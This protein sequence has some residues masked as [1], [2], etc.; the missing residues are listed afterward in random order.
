MRSPFRLRDLLGIVLCTGVL[1]A[2]EPE[3]VIP[4]ADAAPAIDG[5][6]DDACWAEAAVL[7]DFSVAGAADPAKKAKEARL[8]C[9]DQ[10][11]YISVTTAEPAST[12]LR[13]EAKGRASAVWQDDC[14][15]LFIRAGQNQLDYD[16]FITN[17]NG[18]Q[19]DVRRRN[20]KPTGGAHAGWRVASAR[21][22]T[23]WTVEFMIPASDLEIDSFRRADLIGLK[24]GS[25]DRTAR[26]EDPDLSVWPPKASYNPIESVG[27]A[28]IESANLLV[29]PDGADQARWGGDGASSGP[30][31]DGEA[32]VWRFTAPTHVQQDVRMRP[33]QSYKMSF[34]ARAGGDALVRMRAP[35]ADPKADQRMDLPVV[36][37]DGYVAYVKRFAAGPEGKGLMVIGVDDVGAG[38]TW[39]RDLRVSADIAPATSGSAI[40]VI[41]GD[42]PLVVTK[43]RVIDARIERAFCGSA[44]DG[45]VKSGQ[46]DGNYWEYNQPYGGAGVD[47]A[48][49]ANNGYHIAF[50][51]ALGFQAVVVRG[52]VQAKL[53]RDVAAF[54]DP[55]SGSLVY[56]FPGQSQDSRAFLKETAAT[57]RV[58]FFD[59][60]DGR[61]AD[62]SF[63]R[64]HHGLGALEASASDAV[65]SAEGAPSDLVRKHLKE[66]FGDAD[67]ASFAVGGGAAKLDVPGQRWVH[68]LSQ[69]LAEETALAAI[70][71]DLA[72]AAPAPGLQLTVRVQDPLNPRLEL[73]GADYEIAGNGRARIVCDFPD[74]IVPKG[75]QLWVSLRS[76]RPVTLAS[77]RVERY[78]VARAQ[79]QAEALAYRTFLL[80]SFYS[81][82]SEARP[83]NQWWKPEDEA[84]FVSSEKGYSR[85]VKEIVETVEQCKAIDPSDDLT[86]QYDQWIHQNILRRAKQM[87]PYPT[88]FD[89]IPG[90]PEWASLAHQAWMQAREVP[91]WWLD[92]RM[93][94]TG[95]IGGVVGD[96]TD[97]FGNYAPFPFFERDGVGG[98]VLRAGALLAETAEKNNLE[99]GWN[100]HSTD[101]L[102]AY[103]EGM[104]HE[105]IMLYWNYGDPVYVERCMIAAR[106]LEK[107]TILLPNGHRHFKRGD[108]G[109]VDVK[110][111]RS[112][113]G[114]GGAHCLMVHPALEAAWYNR[115]P[116]VVQM[117]KEYGGGWA[118]HQEPGRYAV[119]VKVPEDT[120]SET[121]PNTPFPAL[122]AMAG[123]TSMA[124]AEITGDA[125]YVKPYIDWVAKGN[126]TLHVPELIE[127]GMY[128]P[129]EADKDVV[130]KHWQT[131]L[132]VH[133]GKGAMIEALKA[134][135][136]ELQRF[137]HMY[138]TVE[139]FTDRVFLYPLNNVST[140]YTGAYS[141]RNKLN[142]PYA[143]SWDGF[144]T[145]YAALVTAA[146][147]DRL[148]VLVCNLSDKPL[149]GRAK[150][151]RL[152]HG[153]YDVT[154]A[155][156]A[157][158]DDRADQP[159]TA[160][161]LELARGAEIDLAL[162]AKSVQVLEIRQT[163]KLD[164]IYAR[165]DLALSP[166]DTAVSGGKVVGKVHN[167]GNKPAAAV[168]ALVDPAGA[169]VATVPVGTIEAPLDLTPRAVAFELP[170]VPAQADG[171]SVLVDQDG[172]VPEIYEGNNRIR[173]GK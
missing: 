63:F 160:R 64:V 11:L 5:N 151:W 103:E 50:A 125:A 130:E 87:P 79:A 150:V 22:E 152:E 75:A 93:V 95:E 8:C 128:A 112:P 136:E 144:G 85:W 155:P 119:S 27:R 143:V 167:I 147:T 165:A 69:P 106:G 90:V 20:G 68:V 31:R 42:Q 111:D 53:Y 78:T 170:G 149:T 121:D 74:Q 34:E 65:A 36:R 145:D 71:I 135:I 29:S 21:T 127:L 169:V 123:S 154:L 159:A 44:V 6:L 13:A 172:T 148:K 83:W 15:E 80:R 157:D 30:A 129:G 133:G 126:W 61:L 56:E 35:Q 82:M 102:H 70:G 48:Y 43:L 39:I 9:T 120:A 88:R 58:S 67:R 164:D 12:K 141:T 57:G 77:A 1:P 40:P 139:C 7:K 97:M 101:P 14:I 156:D 51:D 117:L 19:E 76:E 161:P 72:F 18:A 33:G 142:H 162:P 163:A 166:L 86:R 158:G 122:W 92:H 153:R 124:I 46:W 134:D 91:K 59:V 10:A 2:E 99:L 28:F 38:G 84:A 47:Y 104:N 23:A 118:A 115:G 108:T 32:L 132:I 131:Q 137:K 26:R 168:V 89:A 54:D 3:V 146:T 55:K 105:S 17:A 110:N 81:V 37:S 107:A 94:P 100:I 113:E 66:R 73:H 49:F 25:E 171:W 41:A 114:D 116:R 140:A 96:D 16:Q 52:G 138:T 173:L 109:S 60:G 24:I 98:Q 45:S 4:R 62:C